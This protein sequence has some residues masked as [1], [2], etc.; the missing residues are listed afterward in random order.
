MCSLFQDG[1]PTGFFASSTE[2]ALTG[3]I[4]CGRRG[5]EMLGSGHSTHA[6]VNCIRQGAPQIRLRDLPNDD[7]WRALIG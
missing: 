2:L 6:S 3:I 4:I 1:R 5:E 7:I